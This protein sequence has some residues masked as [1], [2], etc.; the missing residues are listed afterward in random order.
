M[1]KKFILTRNDNPSLDILCP[2]KNRVEIRTSGTWTVPAGVTQID[3]FLVGGGGGGSYYYLYGGS[4][5]TKHYQ[6]IA[7]TPGQTLTITIGAGG[8]SYNNEDTTSASTNGG[9]T[10]VIIGDKSY[11]AG[12]GNLTSTAVLGSG[13]SGGGHNG[14]T[15]SSSSRGGDGLA[16]MNGGTGYSFS[17]SSS[18]GYRLL[19]GI[20]QGIP[21]IDPYTGI[22]YGFGNP[23]RGPG[24]PGYSY[25]P[26]SG[27]DGSAGTCIIYY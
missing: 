14:A 17:G 24:Y 21:T 3:L 15:S 13:G 1:A 6:K 16:G 20:G 12:G 23:S 18:S 22:M 4:G 8:H 5:Y 9:N 26:S 7:V 25:S 19:T 10:S 11:D 2:Y 27:I